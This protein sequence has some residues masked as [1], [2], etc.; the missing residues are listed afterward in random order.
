MSTERKPRLS[1]ANL[2]TLEHLD[3]LIAKYGDSPTLTEL[4]DACGTSVST[5]R[6]HVHELWKKGELLVS[7]GAHRGIRRVSKDQAKSAEVEIVEPA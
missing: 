3:R 4:A 7:P 1:P 5:A 6:Y 2:H